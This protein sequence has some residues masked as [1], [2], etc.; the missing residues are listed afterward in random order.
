MGSYSP[1]SAKNVEFE[2]ADI[3]V[4]P[5]VTLEEVS[6]GVSKLLEGP[7]KPEFAGL[8]T[9]DAAA[10]GPPPKRLEDPPKPKV[11]LDCYALLFM[12]VFP[13]APVS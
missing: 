3:V 1:T 11:F 4:N 7:P 9:E 12:S 13:E 5:S 8:L 10:Y 2:V 6:E